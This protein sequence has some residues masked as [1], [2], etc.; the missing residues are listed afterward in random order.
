V[1]FNGIAE[2]EVSSAKAIA[3]AAGVA[4]HRIVRIPD[5]RE[6]GDM[7]AKGKFAGLPPTYIPSRNMIFYSLAA[8][9]AEETGADYIIGGHNRDDL[10]IF[11]DTSREF[12]TS[13]QQ[14]IWSSSER[15]RKRRTTILRPL[16][17]RTKPEVIPLA[18]ELEVP[19]GLT[20]SC[21]A[22]GRVPCL[23]CEGCINRREAF[24][25]AG[26]VDPLEKPWSRTNV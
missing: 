21:H 13:L 2:G 12:F 14:T 1:L 22:V 19:L 18:V 8:S 15:L 25:K 11:E 16:Q 17:N 24:A 23:R 4:E 5:L 3:R 9:F 7:E 6:V 26:V 10:R 20:W